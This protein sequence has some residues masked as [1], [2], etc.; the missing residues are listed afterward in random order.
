MMHTLPL[1]DQVPL[2]LASLSLRPGLTAIR[3]FALIQ[4]FCINPGALLQARG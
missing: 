4:E 1:F 2:A 3:S